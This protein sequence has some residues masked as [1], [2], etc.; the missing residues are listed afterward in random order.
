MSD[1]DS[2][3]AQTAGPP[4]LHEPIPDDDAPGRRWAYPWWGMV[5]VS[6]FVLYH[7]TILLVHNLPGGG[8]AKGLHA[9]FNKH[10]HMSAY[11]RATGNTQSW[12]MFAPNPHRSN[13][14]MRV[15]VKDKDGEIWDLKHDI[16]GRRNYPYLFY[17]RIGKINRRIVDQ[18]GYRRYYA[19][20]VCRDWERTH[21]GESAVEVQFVKLWTQVPPPEKVFGFRDKRGLPG[22]LVGYDPM[23]LH[24]H[25]REEET[26]RCATTRQAQ[27]PNY[28]RQRYGLPEAPENHFLPLQARTWWDK[29]QSKQRADERRKGR[30]DGE[31]GSR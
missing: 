18:K 15:F 4:I 21:G 26:V 11:M 30:E 27:L 24:L 6:A 29:Q 14:F 23:G 20:W 7:V 31:G 16:Y 8:L 5:I 13:T 9:W 2:I 28:L 17:D 1:D 19:A 10:A 12:A 3:D 25:Q 22:W